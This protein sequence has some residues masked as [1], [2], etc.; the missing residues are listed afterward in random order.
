MEYVLKSP[1]R[2]FYGGDFGLILI[3][4]YILIGVAVLCL[5]SYSVVSCLYL[6]FSGLI[7]SIRKERA[8]CY[9]ID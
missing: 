3:S 4:C 5:I 9:A 2:P 7:T 8:D 1:W 6:G